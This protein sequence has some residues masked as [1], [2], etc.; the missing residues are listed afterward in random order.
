LFLLLL[1]LV[2]CG[3]VASAVTYQETCASAREARAR[4][5]LPLWDHQVKYDDADVV[6]FVSED[7]LLVGSVRLMD[8]GEPQLGPLVMYDIEKRKELWRLRRR[9]F[10]ATYCIVATEPL[11]LLRS[12]IRDK[13]VLQ[14]LDPATGRAKWSL[15]LSSEWPC[16]YDTGQEGLR[17]LFL[18]RGKSLSHIDG[19]TG[20]RDWS[21]DVLGPCRRA[22][23]KL[24][25]TAESLY[26]VS[27][28]GVTCVRRSDGTVQWKAEGALE[29]PIEAMTS[30]EE[31]VVYSA[32]R[33]VAF[34]RKDGAPGWTWK[35]PGGTVKL[36]ARNAGAVYAVVHD[37][38][39]HTDTVFAVDRENGKTAWSAD[40]S[41]YV[42]GPLFFHAG[43]LYTT[44]GEH[45]EVTAGMI[46]A[47]I[48]Q[49]HYSGKRR[50]VGLALSDGKKR[51]NA[52]L[53]EHLKS[54]GSPG[55][56]LYAC[57]PDLIALRGGRL[58]VL[59]EDYGI[60]AV[61][62]K[63]GKIPWRQPGEPSGMTH[64][65]ALFC[66]QS[67]GAFVKNGGKSWRA[68]GAHS[69]SAP[70][71]SSRL[72]TTQDCNQSRIADAKRVL[73]DPNASAADRKSA[74]ETIQIAVG[75]QMAQMKIS[76]S[77]QRAQAAAGLATSMINAAVAFRAAMYAEIQRAKVAWHRKGTVGLQVAAR[78][79]QQSLSGKY[80]LS[81][82]DRKLR[83][84]DLDT[85]RRAEVPF[86]PLLGRVWPDLTTAALSP[87]NKLVAT[88]GVGI[89]VDN[90]VRRRKARR[91]VIP[92]SSVI[93][94][95]ISDF[96]FLAAAPPVPKKPAPK[97][98]APAKNAADHALARD[99]AG[100]RAVL[101]KGGS[102]DAK[103]GGTIPALFL[104][105]GLGH[106][107]MVRLL[108]AYGADV[109]CKMGRLTVFDELKRVRDKKKRKAVEKLL[110]DA[111][112]GKRPPKD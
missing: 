48:K 73:G 53:V 86:S 49:L 111:V 11:I 80:Q 62:P 21:A 65:K 104:A 39:K 18:L 54:F 16:A 46:N 85:G 101:K 74:R 71:P 43:T 100:L 3:Q 4:G 75:S 52:R 8:M 32:K 27:C 10:G 35:S 6:R 92:G 68:G 103:Y 17:G 70:A 78:Q 97:I 1:L 33:A 109:N 72:R 50:L 58:L 89:D 105:V 40:L 37:A 102:P 7:L 12:A 88:V 9:A 99:V 61:D 84:I 106:E 95:K 55:T 14:A 90:Y 94:Y 67:S 41:G 44:V 81:P 76:S 30:V 34:G 45:V 56:H 64:R 29:P 107:E 2:A 19:A 57:Q 59:I 51:L 36:M 31:V 15:K 23:S 98:P 66:V 26:A 93:V 28:A 110:K 60:I 69:F 108:L 47:P 20:K 13:V 38:G 24:L 91:V 25:V 96:K 112:G 79:H 22:S 63:T 83:L 42:A 77:F 82:G 87:G 5:P